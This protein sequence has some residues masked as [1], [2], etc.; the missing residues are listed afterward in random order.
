MFLSCFVIRSINVILNGAKDLAKCTGDFV[1]SKFLRE[2][3]RFTQ[4]D[5]FR[6][7]S[8]VIVCCI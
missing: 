7:Y 2:I 4:N 1:F 5:T 6:D 8:I 3:L